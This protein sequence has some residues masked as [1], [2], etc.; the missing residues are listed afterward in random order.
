MS[1]WIDLIAHEKPHCTLQSSMLKWDDALTFNKWTAKLLALFLHPFPSPIGT[2]TK[3]G[4]VRKKTH[5]P[6]TCQPA[7][8]ERS[9]HAA[10]LVGSGAQIQAFTTDGWNS[11]FQFIGCVISPLF[12]LEICLF[13]YCLW[14]FTFG[15]LPCSFS[16]LVHLTIYLIWELIITILW[17]SF[18][19]VIRTTPM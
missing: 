16:E 6:C 2:Q 8:S 9:K 4:E 13:K 14:N 12:E 7:S 19:S 18:L 11:N 1:I 5:R 15:N 3:L 10:S 17:Y